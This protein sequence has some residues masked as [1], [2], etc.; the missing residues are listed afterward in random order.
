[1]AQ[2]NAQSSDDDTDG[3][4]DDSQN[5]D[6][7]SEKDDDSSSGKDDDGQESEK[8]DEIKVAKTETNAA[9]LTQLYQRESFRRSKGY[10]ASGTGS[11]IWRV[12]RL[13]ALALIPLAIWFVVSLLASMTG[14]GADPAAWLGAPINAVLLAAFILLAL[15]HATIGLRV[16]LEDYVHTRAALT[17][18]TLALYA[19]SWLTGLAAIGG[20]LTLFFKSVGGA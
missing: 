12:Q 1:M 19:A 15:R 16:V 7:C 8:D 20:L 11:R 6:N 10:G 5:K 17:T 18:A 9:L 13:T 4:S 14:T 2:D 3:K